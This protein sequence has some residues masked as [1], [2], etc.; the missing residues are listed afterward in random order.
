MEAGITYLDLLDVTQTGIFSHF[1]D[2]L[3]S[4]K[5]SVTVGWYSVQTR[6]EELCLAPVVSS[7]VISTPKVQ[8]TLFFSTRT[9]HLL[10]LT[11]VA[12]LLWDAG[13]RKPLA[14]QSRED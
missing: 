9:A 2:E 4:S 6:L 3:T 11:T 1:V 8:P 14:L 10:F 12:F 13:Q 5:M 7:E